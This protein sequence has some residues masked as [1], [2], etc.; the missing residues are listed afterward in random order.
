L[1]QYAP[2][3]KIKK[4]YYRAAKKY[5]PDLHLGLPEDTKQ[6][7]LEIF[8]YITNAYLTL[9]HLHRRQ[10]YDSCFMQGKPH[11][12]ESPKT[13]KGPSTPE[14]GA[15]NK[16]DDGRLPRDDAS[17]LTNAE[18]AGRRFEEGKDKFRRKEFDEAARLFA[19][20]IYFDG[21][22]P[23]YHF[24]YG[25]A[26]A[27]RGDLKEAA[28]ALNRANE[29]KPTNAD[30]LAELGHVYMDLGFPLRAKGY[31]DRALK[32]D[33]SSRRAKEGIEILGARPQGGV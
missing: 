13:S 19:T 6:K 27:A 14:K 12:G 18:T 17:H 8:T 28:K 11:G 2:A 23:E 29:L 20:A 22:V 33:P 10:E 31:F 3:E 21:S 32:Y 25:R 16:Q 5:H 15:V 24:F 30:I 9:S 4:A 7:L 26:L 1:D